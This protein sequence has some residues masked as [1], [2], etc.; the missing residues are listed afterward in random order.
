MLR[1]QVL[2]RVE[3]MKSIQAELILFP[4][5]MT[6]DFDYAPFWEAVVGVDDAESSGSELPSRLLVH[7]HASSRHAVNA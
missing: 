3:Q 5:V 2:A 7:A 6:Q 1:E 4:M